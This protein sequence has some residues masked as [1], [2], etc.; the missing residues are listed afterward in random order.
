MA[1]VFEIGISTSSGENMQKVN[2]AEVVVGKGLVND[3]Y[4]KTDNNNSCQ[5]TL[6][7]S[8]NIDDYNQL[9][10]TSIPY[11]SFRRNIVTKDIRLNE[12]VGKELSIGKVQL[13]AHRLCEPCLYLQEKLKQENFVKKIL[14]KSGLRCE[15][16][17][18]GTIF[19]GDKIKF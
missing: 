18:S 1:T 11:L 13:K 19:I 4:F 14:H 8:E 16:L 7:E 9:S 6:I 12:L 10:G 15:I 3:R 5:I 2:N 17:K